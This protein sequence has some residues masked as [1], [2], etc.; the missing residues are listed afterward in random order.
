MVVPDVLIQP[1]SAPL[2]IAFY[3][4]SQFPAEYRND[5]F[6]AL[7][8]SWNRGQRTGYKLIRVKLRERQGD[9]RSIEDFMT[10]FV[11]ANGDVWGRPVGVAVTQDGA[12]LM[13]DDGSDTIWRIAY[14]GANATGGAGQ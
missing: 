6:V 1:H 10:G 4:G 13:S 11:M 8:G 9:R 3:T 12:L 2:G 14:G 5:L 7:H